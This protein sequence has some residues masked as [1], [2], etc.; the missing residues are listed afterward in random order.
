MIKE[1]ISY[2]APRLLLLLTTDAKGEACAPGSGGG[3][4]AGNGEAGS[5]GLGTEAFEDCSTGNDP[6]AGCAVGTGVL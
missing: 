6:L 3:C 1:L 2:E 5:C 4:T